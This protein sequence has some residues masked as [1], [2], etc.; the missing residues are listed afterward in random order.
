MIFGRKFEAPRVASVD[1]LYADRTL[2]TSK[3]MFSPPSE[4]LPHVIRFEL[5]EGCDWGK[6][7]YC[8]GFDGVK[9]REKSLED[10]KA[11]VD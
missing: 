10:Y 11:H 5:T 8:G 7:T 3:D 1:E 4:R 9:F 2:Y 6:C